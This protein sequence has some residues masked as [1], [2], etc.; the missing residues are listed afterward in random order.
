MVKIVLL[1]A[2][3]KVAVVFAQCSSATS[4]AALP[5]AD[6]YNELIDTGRMIHYFY[7]N[8][9][10][11]YEIGPYTLWFEEHPDSTCIPSCTITD[12]FGSA[13]TGI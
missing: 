12:A 8:T 7:H 10:T 4:I 11:D 2:F 6:Q 5:D 1:L 3:L 9:L 13:I